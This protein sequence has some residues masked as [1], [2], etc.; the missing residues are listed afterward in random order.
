MHEFYLF[1]SLLLHLSEHLVDFKNPQIRR[2]IL[3]VGEFSGIDVA[4][5]KTV[6]DTFKEGTILDG[7]EILFEIESLKI[8]CKSCG[9]ESEPKE[10]TAKCPLCGSFSVDILAGL[11]LVIKRIEIEEN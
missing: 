3:S 7:A 2:V 1:Q 11:D 9:A 10:K 6:I 8:H 5:F 4:Y